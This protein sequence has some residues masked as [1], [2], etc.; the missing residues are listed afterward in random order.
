MLAASKCIGASIFFTLAKNFA[1][2]RICRIFL[3]SIASSPSDDFLLRRYFTS[4]KKYSSS[5]QVTMSISQYLFFQ[6]RASSLCPCN[7]KNSATT[8]SPLSPRALV[9]LEFSCASM[10][11][12]FAIGLKL[13]LCSGQT[14]YFS[15]A[16]LCSAVP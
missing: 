12:A 8:H 11:N 16:A 4:V 5:F 15:I 9:E 7:I 1:A 2:K 14:P 3:A 10:P 13:R 6:L